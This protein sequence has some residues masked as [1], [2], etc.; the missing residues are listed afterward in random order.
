MRED[1]GHRH[2]YPEHR[3]DV[4][5]EPGRNRLRGEL[6]KH[7]PVPD[8]GDQDHDPE[9]DEPDIEDLRMG[10]AVRSQFTREL[11]DET[12]AGVEQRGHCD[13]TE[14]EDGNGNP[15]LEKKHVQPHERPPCPSFSSAAT[16]RSVPSMQVKVLTTA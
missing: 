3:D 8:R 2:G 6:G 15:C 14:V 13:R 12:E 4:A 16:S 10:S 11:A 7:S 1:A 9:G 5:G